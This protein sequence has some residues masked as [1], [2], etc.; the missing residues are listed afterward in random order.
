MSFRNVPFSRR[1]KREVHPHRQRPLLSR[2]RERSLGESRLAIAPRRRQAH[3]AALGHPP[4]Q[5]GQ[6]LLAVDQLRCGCVKTM[7]E[8]VQHK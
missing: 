7:R 8:R 2:S 6:L 4:H 5:Q 1:G 3:P